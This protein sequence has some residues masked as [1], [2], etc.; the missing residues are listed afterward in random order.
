[1]KRILL[2]LGFL[3]FA[4]SLL[5]QGPPSNYGGRGGQPK[6]KGKITGTV[7]DSL[8]GEPVAYASILLRK[9]ADNSQQDG[10]ITEDNGQFKFKDVPV[11]KYE[12]EITF[13]GYNSSVIA[14]ETTPEKPDANLDVIFLGPSSILLEGVTVVEEA[15]LIENQIDKIVYNAEKDAGLA[16]A[17]ATE[18][19]RKVPLLSVDL[20]GNISLRGSG[21]VQ[22]LINGRPSALLADNPGEVL[23]SIPAEQIKSVEVITTPTAKYDGEGSAGIINIITK[24]SDIEGFSGSVGG[25]VGNISNNYSLNAS[26]VFGRFG[27]NLNGGGWYSW[28]RATLQDYYREDFT[29]F[30]TSTIQDIGEGIGERLGFRGSA[31]AYYDFNAFNS[32]SSSFS[33]R[34][35][36][37]SNDNLTETNR[38]DAE[39][40]AI[41]L[42]SIESISDQRRN[43]FEWTTDYRKKFKTEKQELVLA[44]QWDGSF[45]NQENFF[46][47]LDLTGLDPDLDQKDIN[48]NNGD[49]N[50]YTVQL[51]YTH[52][53][54]KWLTI[55]TG[56]KGVLR[57][58]DSDFSGSNFNFATG[59]YELVPDRTD[60][61]FYNQDVYAGYLSGTFTFGSKWGLVAGTRYE[62]TTILSR[63][64]EDPVGD[65]NSYD[66]IL[67]SIILSYKLSQ[68]STLKASF[69]QRIQ[70]PGLRFVN[71]YNNQANSLNISIGNPFLDPERVDQ[72]DLSFSTF[73]KRTSINASI[74]YRYTSDIIEPFIVVEDG[75][76]ITNFQN[77]GTNNSVGVNLFVST[78]IKQWLT[79]RGGFNIFTYDGQGTINGVELTNQAILFNG[80][81]SAT[82]NLPKDFKIEAFSFFRSPSQS[83]QGRRTS[84][85][86]YTFGFR[87]EFWD[88]RASLGLRLVSPFQQFI[89]FRNEQSGETFNLDSSFKIPIR[90][91]GV[92]FNYRFGKLD[93]RDRPRRSAID[94]D[95]VRNGDD[96]GQ[97]F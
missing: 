96:G 95:D 38:F 72:Y 9:V 75:V 40:G 56:A 81:L 2:S 53:V 49:N 6:I 35:F 86:I 94:N 79:L 22:I 74:F 10:T 55:E 63:F 92:S 58:I 77:I 76:A 16:G 89:D 85:Y 21:N 24:R 13:V 54:G 29:P 12:L 1:M 15:A 62:H 68:T 28:P 67:P 43:G 23:Q 3:C 88:K 90:S 7:L 39:T 5:A 97:G 73:V 33:M 41:D 18:L 20:E 47:Q 8:S 4:L 70:R 37:R 52:P 27:L 57:R 80:N 26:A 69:T 65:E 50:E 82:F 31:S 71:P 91:I 30:G 14:V 61:F 87:K 59:M 51:D 48:T 11:G 19:L 17:D 46:T 44:F 66:N 42:F 36:N 45:S 84:F 25:S 78:N 32:I 64:E 93:F 83:L 34:G 60:L